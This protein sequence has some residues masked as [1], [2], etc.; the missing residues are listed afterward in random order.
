MPSPSGYAQYTKLLLMSPA[1]DAWHLD[2][3]CRERVCYTVAANDVIFLRCMGALWLTLLNLKKYAKLHIIE[4]HPS[5]FRP[6]C[7]LTEKNICKQELMQVVPLQVPQHF[8]IPVL[9]GDETP[10]ISA[11]PA[12]AQLPESAQEAALPEPEQKSQE[13]PAAAEET[14]I[15]EV[16]FPDIVAALKEHK[17]EAEEAHADASVTSEA[18]A[19]AAEESA[20]AA[21]A[22]TAP[23]EHRRATAEVCSCGAPLESH[24]FSILHCTDHPAA[25]QSSGIAQGTCRKTVYSVQTPAI[26]RYTVYRLLP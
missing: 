19:A 3:H 14:S 26:I 25:C 8:S 24:A 12:P 4:G 18:A 10:A 16:P 23:A 6:V 20:P 15:A 11:A 9:G 17:Q 2:L 13:T 22:A 5:C 7:H 1:P 21:A